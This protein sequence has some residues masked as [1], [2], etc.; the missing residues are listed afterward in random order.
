[1]SFTLFF[2]H[3]FIT[4][5]QRSSLKEKRAALSFMEN[6]LASW[7]KLASKTEVQKG[8]REQSGGV[9]EK[10]RSE[11]KTTPKILRKGLETSHRA[12]GRVQVGGNGE[13]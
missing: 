4:S 12:P 6:P 5:T 7:E 2:E 1:M 10:R 3:K 8:V 9:N 11:G 13:S